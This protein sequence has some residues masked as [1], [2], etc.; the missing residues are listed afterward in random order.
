MWN[1]IHQAN[2]KNFLPTIDKKIDLVIS[3]PPYNIGKDF[4]NSTDKQPLDVYLAETKE[5]LTMCRDLL[6]ER[7]SIV[8][9]GTHKYVGYLQTMMYDLG[10]HYKRMLIWYY[11]NGT[12][13]QRRTPVTEYEPILWFTKSETDFTYNIDEMRIPYRTERVKNPCYKKD[14]N[15]VK[16]AWLPNPLGALRGDVWKYPVL[17]GKLYEKERTEHPTQKP[18]SLI[19]DLIRAFCPK[20]GIVVDPYM[21]SGT[22]GVCCEKLNL[23]WTGCE[24]EEKWV[25][26]GNKRIWDTKERSNTEKESNENK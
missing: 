11:L 9:F 20:D 26:I 7:G 4:G 2:C 15:G 18:V 17:S 21:G 10:L 16:R 6:S 22:V 24:L 25:E 23:Q 1:M 3:D 13:R 8:W 14:A 12:S 5:I 19:L